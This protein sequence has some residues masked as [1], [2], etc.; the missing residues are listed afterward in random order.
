MTM[1][2]EPPLPPARNVGS[3]TD[4]VFH[5][6]VRLVLMMWPHTAAESPPSPS[7]TTPALA[8]TMSARP[9]EDMPS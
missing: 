4:T 2:M 7:R 3:A 1:T 9:S 6:P 5:A 8:R